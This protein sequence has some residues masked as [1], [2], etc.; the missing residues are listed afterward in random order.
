M[1]LGWGGSSLIELLRMTPSVM[2][3]KSGGVLE[4][5]EGGAI[6]CGNILMEDGGRIPDLYGRP[7]VH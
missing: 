1:L 7:T 5:A 3:M 2:L 4:D 6:A